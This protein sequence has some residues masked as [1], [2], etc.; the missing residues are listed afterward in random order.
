LQKAIYTKKLR[1]VVSSGIETTS[2]NSNTRICLNCSLPCDEIVKCNE[3]LS[4]LYCSINCLTDDKNHKQLC[5]YIVKLEKLE[6]KKKLKSFS[7]SYDVTLPFKKYKKLVDVIGLKPMINFIL[8]DKLFSGLW[9]TGSMVSLINSQ[10]L[11][12]NFQNTQIHPIETFINNSNG[13]S[14]TAANNSD[15][16]IEGIAVFDFALPN[17]NYRISAPFLVTN[18]NLSDP[19]IGFNI[20]Q[21]IT[22]NHD[23]TSLPDCL[24]SAIPVLDS[25][26]VLTVLSIINDSS[27]KSD[28]LGAVKPFKSFTLPANSVTNLKCKVRIGSLTK[29][30]LPVMFEPVLNQNFDY[31]LS[32]ALVILK[33]GNCSFITIPVENPT[34]HPIK[35]PP[36]LVLGTVNSISAV[37]PLDVSDSVTRL[38]NDKVTSRPY[39]NTVKVKD[40][41]LPNIDL[42]HLPI[43]ERSKA[44]ALLKNY[45]DIFSKS[46]SDIGSTDL[47]LKLNLKDE[48][49]VYVAY[50][51]IPKPLYQE[52]KNHL[53]DLLTNGWIK[54]SYSSFASPMVCVRKKDNSLRLCIDYREVNQKIIP[55]RMPLPR[56][57]DIIE[58]LGGQSWFSTLDL[59]K[60]YHQGYMH[61]DSQH[62]TA[63]ST[64]WALLEWSRIPI[65]LNNAPPSFQRYIN[66]CLDDLLDKI[67]SAYLDDILA[68]GKTFDQHLENLEKLF[69]RLRKHGFKLNPD[70]CDLFRR[71][72]KYLGKIISSDG[73]QDDPAKTEALNSLLVTPTTIGD[74]RKILGFI[75]YY[76][77]SIKDFSRKVKPLYDLLSQPKPI[78]KSRSN[79]SKKTLGQKSSKEKI[80]HWLPEHKGIILDIIEYL[81]SPEVM[82]YPDFEK[83]FVIHCDASETGLGAVLYQEH[84]DQLKVV[85]YASR[86]L[87]PAEKNYYLHSGKLEFL[88]LK[89]SITEKFREYLYY[90]PYFTVFTDNNPLSYVLSSAKLNATGM[91]WIAELADF[92]FVIKYRSGKENID[93]DYL[94]RAPI[95][96]YIKSCNSVID[97]SSIH[98]L[99][100]EKQSS[101]LP[102][103]NINVNAVE[104]LDTPSNFHNIEDAKLS[105]RQQTDSI[106]SPI[107]NSVSSESKIK[108]HDFKPLSRKSK[109]LCRFYDK[110]F[111]NEKGV[112][113]KKGIFNQVVLPQVYK[114]LVFEELHCNLGH[115][116]A[117][118]VL[119]LSKKRFY[120]PGM[121]ADIFNFVRKKCKCIISKKPN[122]SVKAPLV[123]IT[124]T[125]PFELISID[126]LHLDKSK[127]GYEYLLVVIDHFTRF[128]QAYPTKNKSAKSA[129]DKIFNDF[130][131]N[132]GYPK[133]IHHDLGAEFNNT[134][135]KSLRHLSGIKQSH[136]TPYH[137]MGNGQCER[138]NRTIINM[139]K[140]LP[141]NFKLNWHLHVKKLT[142]AYNSTANKSTGFSPFYL[143]FGREARLP[144]DQIFNLEANTL[145][146]NQLSHAQFVNNWKDT[147]KQA[148]EIVQKHTDNMKSKSKI[149]YDKN[150]YGNE[151]KP[152]DKVLIKNFEKG[153]TG[154]L[155]NYWDDKIYIVRQKRDNLPVFEVEL[156]KGGNNKI[157]TLHRN[158]LYKC[159]D[160]NLTQSH[161]KIQN[162]NLINRN[163]I[164]KTK[165]KNLTDSSS[166]SD[167]DSEIDQLEV[168]LNLLRQKK[169]HKLIPTLD[170]IEGG[171]ECHS[172][173]SNNDVNDS[174]IVNDPVLDISDDTVNNLDFS[175]EQATPPR[176]S[177]RIRNRR[178]VFTYD[179]SGQPS[180][181]EL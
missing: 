97:Q 85:S 9:D 29:N 129:A 137:P 180:Y 152:G 111:I 143:I 158:L 50:R 66:K 175:L 15:I 117:D 49:P 136:T 138:F 70:K 2:V 150:I 103:V 170:K 149:H 65:G 87:T 163:L 153:G 23:V 28:I 91:R 156:E 8:N 155:R 146:P 145:K 48:T 36:K 93:A 37:I 57:T 12:Q 53:N 105:L 101:N 54:Q 134:L 140:T 84:N 41:F 64:P 169:K 14:L 21:H 3:C 52:V 79:A 133:R 7:C 171:E 89:W 6:R 104:Y 86:T 55:D 173:N 51:K 82:G 92:N 132:F 71:K 90:G 115:L 1:K 59:S 147:M 30:R 172:N 76:R 151:L 80:T 83:P 69:T 20:I 106:I 98:T 118:K 165:S 78:D 63:F 126:Y 26:D 5:D 135:F 10:W 114:D 113:I 62:I 125:E 27:E 56:M 18:Q 128:V 119:D 121:A 141:S 61:E 58:N 67:C 60:A 94:S 43:E 174:Y 109:M 160:L 38:K 75:G 124:S 44:E 81:K 95:T 112:L 157:K 177:N 181:D 72:V 88:A 139:L 22:K 96:E 144:I 120:W 45:C 39:V 166:E 131:L 148:F 47:K 99:F 159:N 176:R 130:I 46:K 33:R 31:I 167:S 16:S 42:S 17:S 77:S 73:Y 164:T 162:Q 32:D 100:L 102:H 179:D 24:K 40:Q 123:N 116:G 178:K 25:S 168:I 11:K 127:G 68:Y 19:I 13:I 154:K 107:Y 108:S 35:L 142:H 161:T 110:L 4:G 122:L 74:L 34:N